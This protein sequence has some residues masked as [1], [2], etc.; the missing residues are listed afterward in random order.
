MINQVIG[1]IQKM[2]STDNQANCYGTAL[3]AYIVSRNPQTVEDI[4][5]LT[6]EFDQHLFDKKWSF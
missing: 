5:L 1:Y 3:E 6:R 4:E 2:F